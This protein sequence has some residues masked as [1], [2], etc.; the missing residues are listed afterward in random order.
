MSLQQ[1]E[2]ENL[3]YGQKEKNLQIIN[4]LENLGILDENKKQILIQQIS[5]KKLV[6]ALADFFKKLNPSECYDLAVRL[7][8]QFQIKQDLQTKEK[9]SLN[10]INSQQIQTKQQNKKQINSQIQELEED[11]NEDMCTQQQNEQNQK[12]NYYSD[13]TYYSNSNQNIKDKINTLQ[14]EK[15]LK[16]SQQQQDNNFNNTQIHQNFNS[17]NSVNNNNFLQQPQIIFKTFGNNDESLNKIYNSQQFSQHLQSMQ[18]NPQENQ[19]NLYQNQIDKNAIKVLNNEDNSFIDENQNDE[20]SNQVSIM[21]EDKFYEENEQQDKP[22]NLYDDI[23]KNNDS[24]FNQECNSNSFLTRSSPNK[25]E[26]QNNLNNISGIS[27]ISA[28]QKNTHRFMYQGNQNLEN[29]EIINQNS[30]LNFDKNLQNQQNSQ[31]QKGQISSKAQDILNRMKKEI[32]KNQNYQGQNEKKQ[33]VHEKLYQQSSVRKQQQELLQQFNKDKELNHCTFKPKI[34]RNYSSKNLNKSENDINKDNIQLQINQNQDISA[35]KQN[36]A[37]EYNKNISVFEKLYNQ[38][39]QLKDKQK[40]WQDMKKHQSLKDCSFQ[41]KLIA[42]Q[43]NS[44]NNNNNSNIQ[45]KEN[46]PAYER[47]YQQGKQM[48]DKKQN[49]IDEKNQQELSQFYQNNKGV[50]IPIIPQMPVGSYIDSSA[51]IQNLKQQNED[52]NELSFE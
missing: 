17:N 7:I 1:E 10:S 29:T 11:K 30:F 46:I 15:E 33:N 26:N 31:N 25:Q 49:K 43:Y 28:I 4:F 3:E 50:N 23:N 34:N 6:F 40:Q 22:I 35:K 18:Q 13:N 37:K 9:Q 42:K 38:Q 41:P 45:E 44:K 20:Y 36:I 21:D 19:Q 51:L 12:N 5:S 14:S 48:E 39:E 16:Q 27:N 2:V 47:L 32:N 52:V 24:N 8:N